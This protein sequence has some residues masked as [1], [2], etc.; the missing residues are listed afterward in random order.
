[1]T[2]H[3]ASAQ[4]LPEAGGTRFVWIE[5]LLPHELGPTIAGMIQTEPGAIKQT[6]EGNRAAA[7]SRSRSGQA[8]TH[9]S[10]AICRA[11]RWAPSV[12]T[13][14]GADFRASSSEMAA[15]I[16]SRVSLA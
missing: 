11:A 15:A 10:S 7:R 2:H 9:K 14:S 3:D 4:V 12:S 1:M 6:L 16:D 5:D 13:S 8:P